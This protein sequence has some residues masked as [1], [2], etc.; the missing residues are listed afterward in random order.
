MKL[1]TTPNKLPDC[2]RT[3]PNIRWV[4]RSQGGP[5][6]PDNVSEDAM[7]L[8]QLLQDGWG[9]DFWADVQVEQEF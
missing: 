5:H 4:I 9:H 3:E 1:S 7:V 8:Q 2:Q 6:L